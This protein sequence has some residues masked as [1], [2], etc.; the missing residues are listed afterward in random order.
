VTRERI[1]SLTGVLPLGAYL[2][3]HLFEASSAVGGRRAFV[4]GM[5]G[6]GGGSALLFES[7]LVLLPLA[8]HI[9]LGIAIWA[10]PS[11]GVT[12]PHPTTAFRTIQRVT[13][14]VVL[15]F[16]LFHLGHTFAL[17]VEGADANALYDRLWVQLGTPLYIG[18]YVI[19]TAAVALHL[20]NGLPA[21]ARRFD[22]VKTEKAY[23][24]VRHLS[25]ALAILLFLA[26]VN[27]LSH[28]VVGD[29]FFGGR[30]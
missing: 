14:V 2:V 28:F 8:V 24:G 18:V 13:G 30:I 7:V 4:D 23:R 9:G 1:H 19:G 25:A 20:A 29:S 15:A 10:R 11:P 21:A 12:S 3:L 5:S 17:E 27:T 16:L 6:V 22:L 26:T